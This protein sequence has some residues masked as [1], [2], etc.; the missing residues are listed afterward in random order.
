MTHP[1]I[2]DRFA[3]LKNRIEDHLKQIQEMLT[4]L[5]SSTLHGLVSD[6]RSGLNEPFLFV[7]VGEVK[8]GKSS[9]INALLGESICACII[10]RSEEKVSLKEIRE[11]LKEKIA[12]HKLPDELCVM[13]DFPRLSGS[14][15]IK[16]F[17]KDGLTELAEKDR[18]RERIRK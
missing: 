6:M 3:L 15:K 8:S 16:K 2:D 14:I 10:P 4:G 11:F 17:G 5:E 13:D 12:P 18:S 1:V 9:F 7:V